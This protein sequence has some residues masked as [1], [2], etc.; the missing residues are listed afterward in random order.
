MPPSQTQRPLTMSAVQPPGWAPA[1]VNG[2]PSNPF[3]PA[4]KAAFQAMIEDE[5][6][7][8]RD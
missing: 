6:Y 4:V 3:P 8:N 7:P 5:G 2:S 1:T